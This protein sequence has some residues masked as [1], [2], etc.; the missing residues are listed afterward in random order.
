[1]IYDYKD[2]FMVNSVSDDVLRDQEMRAISEA[3]LIGVT[4]EPFREKIVTYSVYMELALM[5]MESD[6]MSEKYTGY[7]KEY[8]R[9]YNMTK[10]G[11]PS[12][13]SNISIG[14]G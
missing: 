5:Q 8:D 3:D 13:V 1:M 11:S 14:R 6:G 2:E 12:N 7:R 9:Y 10:V 4:Q